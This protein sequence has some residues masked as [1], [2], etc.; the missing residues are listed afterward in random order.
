MQAVAM[1]DV[2]KIGTA[3]QLVANGQRLRVVMVKACR[4]VNP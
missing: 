4:R 2:C 1:P 3:P